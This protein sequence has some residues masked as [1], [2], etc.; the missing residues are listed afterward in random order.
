[1]KK[2]GIVVETGDSVS[3]SYAMKKL[4]DHK[5]ELKSMGIRSRKN[6]ETMANMKVY[7][8]EMKMLFERCKD[9]DSFAFRIKRFRNYIVTS[10]KIRKL[11]MNLGNI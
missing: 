8:R 1:M 6:Y 9:K 4:I 7:E 3:L 11:R 5:C 10:D 2:S